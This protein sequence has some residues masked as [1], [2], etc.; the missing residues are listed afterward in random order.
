MERLRA[1]APLRIGTSSARRAV[2]VQ[3]FLREALPATGD[4]PPQLEVLPLRGPVEQRLRWLQ[5]T[6]DHPGALD[7]VILALAGLARLWGDR[8]GHAVV[9]PLLAGTR[10]MVLPLTAC[11]TAPGQGALAVEC[12]AGDT[13]TEA[14]LGEFHDAETERCVRREL[15]LLA[16]VPVEQRGGFGATAVRHDSCGPL[17]F[18]RGADA[19]NSSGRVLWN[20]P[21]RPVAARIWDGAEWIRASHDEALSGAAIGEPP[22]VFLA[23]WRA[24][25]AGLRLHAATRLWVSGTAS[26]RRLAREGLW[27]EGCADNLG[28]AFIAPTLRSPVLQL[29]PLAAW[30]VLT[31]DDAMASWDD[32]A[33]G[34]VIAT[35][36]VTPP[37]DDRTLRAIR[38]QVAGATHFF[39]G[40]AA[41]FRAVRDWL[42]ANSH[43][44]CGPGKTYR[45]L[46]QAGVGNLQA[47]PSRQ[48]WHA[49]VA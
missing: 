27:I 30:T 39:W 43:H 18:T 29:P 36:K 46:R 22:A 49:W 12:R 6:P 41:Q 35:Y 11:P 25:N 19:G 48:E 13:R 28:F 31:R 9:A 14:V 37:A 44:S 3:R 38:E 47:F 45:A 8:A 34:R 20:M 40:S 24:F 32:G 15:H 5:V 42:P 16:Q 26:W 23:H 33:V 10:L 2:H 21:P 17:T 4:V 7:S 1:A